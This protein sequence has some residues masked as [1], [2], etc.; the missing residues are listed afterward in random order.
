MEKVL[1]FDS[2]VNNFLC[3]DQPI[4]IRTIAMIL[5]NGCSKDVRRNALSAICPNEAKPQ[6][7]TKYKMIPT[8]N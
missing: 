2:L 6:G 4:V 3:L 5:I 7:D 8:N 1:N